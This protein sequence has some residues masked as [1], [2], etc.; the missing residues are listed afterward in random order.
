M[1]AKKE[2]KVRKLKRKRIWPSIIFY[3]IF[4]FVGVGMIFVFANWFLC[5]TFEV[6]LDNLNYEAE[7]FSEIISTD[8]KEN[9]G[10]SYIFERIDNNMY[11]Y[12]EFCIIDDSGSIVVQNGKTNP[13]FSKI[14]K[15]ND[16]D[17][18]SN[19]LYFEK[20]EFFKTDIEGNWNISLSGPEMM[21][22]LS[23]TV[24]SLNENG[25]LRTQGNALE[26]KC[27]IGCDVP[28]TQ[29]KMFLHDKLGVARKDIIYVVSAD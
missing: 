27:W 3:L 14:T 25:K 18:N 8:I 22:L 28:N 29:Y 21:K 10:I 17:Y 23:K 12:S 9:N 11:S 15:V 1:S 13:E 4:S 2:K 24:D 19:S 16:Y 5:Y 26:V 20:N 6:R 7:K